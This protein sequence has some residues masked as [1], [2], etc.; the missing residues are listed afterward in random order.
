MFKANSYP[1]IEPCCY[2]GQEKKHGLYPLKVFSMD[3][4]GSGRE[5]LWILKGC[6]RYRF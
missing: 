5:I 2:P 4:P 1:C 6:L 3:I